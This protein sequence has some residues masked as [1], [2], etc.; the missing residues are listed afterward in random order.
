M[1]TGRP[2]S[3]DLLDESNMP[4]WKRSKDGS[5]KHYASPFYRH[6]LRVLNATGLRA[7]DKGRKSDL[8]PPPPIRLLLG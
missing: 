4:A 1:C 6:R 7:A 2:I 5:I 3:P 8:P